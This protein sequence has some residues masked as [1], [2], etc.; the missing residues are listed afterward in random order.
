L[1]GLFV[2]IVEKVVN[3]SMR[4]VHP[5]LGKANHV[6]EPSYLLHRIF[7]VTSFVVLP[8]SPTAFELQAEVKNLLEGFLLFGFD[9]VNYTGLIGGFTFVVSFLCGNTHL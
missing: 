1:H 3:V 5:S 2:A 7:E 9:L 4:N 8:N 6:V